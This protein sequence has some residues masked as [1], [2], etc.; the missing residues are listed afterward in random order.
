MT[1]FHPPISLPPI[2]TDSIDNL[3]TQIKGLRYRADRVMDTPVTGPRGQELTLAQAQ[4]RAQ[5]LGDA[6]DT[7][8]THGSQRHRGVSLVAK[9][10]VLGI[11]GVIDFPIML[12]L[13]SSVFNVDWVEPLDL[14][15]AISVVI[16]LLATGGAAAALYH[17]G[18]DQRQYKNHRRQLETSQLTLG[19]KISIAAVTLLVGLIAVVMFVRVWTEGMLSGL[20]NLAL[21]LG[22]LVSAVMLISA[23]L[24]FWIAFRDGSPE[25]DDLAYYTRLVQRHLRIRRDYEDSA[26]QL[27]DQIELIN[28]KTTRTDTRVYVP[29]TNGSVHHGYSVP[30]QRAF[31]PDSA[32]TA[33]ANPSLA[34]DPD[35]DDAEFTVPPSSSLSGPSSSSPSSSPSSSH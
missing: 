22:L 6:I 15:L 17:L 12:W 11:V 32:P 35:D 20:E 23:W 18:H 16:S 5:K 1:G 19:S 8:E 13:V 10:T 21:L 7:E 25:R 3:I 29:S 9:V 4:E 34:A 31:P 2:P 28:L 30:S 24:V 14:P 26:H 33:I 27:E